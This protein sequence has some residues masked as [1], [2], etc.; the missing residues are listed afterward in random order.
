MLSFRHIHTRC[1]KSRLCGKDEKARELTPGCTRLG[2]QE[3]L[4]VE[5]TPAK[6]AWWLGNQDTWAL[7]PPLT[8]TSDLAPFRPQFHY[9]SN[10]RAALINF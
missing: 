9:L 3:S 4:G 6:D 10:K 5:R 2:S 7:V 1:L 8:L